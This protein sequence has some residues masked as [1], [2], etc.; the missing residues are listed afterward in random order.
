MLRVVGDLSKGSFRRL[1]HK[2]VP[3][4]AQGHGLRAWRSGHRV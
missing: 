2:G 3:K 4:R 1:L